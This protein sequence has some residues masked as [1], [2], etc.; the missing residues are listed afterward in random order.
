MDVDIDV[1]VGMDVDIDVIVLPRSWQR[2]CQAH[3]RIQ[4][5]DDAWTAKQSD[6]ATRHVAEQGRLNK[7][8]NKQGTTAHLEPNLAKMTAANAFIRA[9]ACQTTHTQNV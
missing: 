1:R 5:I 2:L 9:N 4:V 6:D 7:S 8:G 3:S